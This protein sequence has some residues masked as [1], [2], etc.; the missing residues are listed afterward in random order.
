MENMMFITQT[1]AGYEIE[2]TNG[3]HHG[4]AETRAEAV[5]CCNDSV[6]MGLATAWAFNE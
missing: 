3:A 6:E 5:Q 1:E 4:T 2:D